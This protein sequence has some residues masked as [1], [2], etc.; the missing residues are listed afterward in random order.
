M[1]SLLSMRQPAFVAS[2]ANAFTELPF[3][4]PVLR[5]IID[6]LLISSTTP[7]SEAIARSVSPGKHISDYLPCTGKVQ[8]KLS[9]VT[10]SSNTQY[11]LENAPTARD[12]ARLR[13]TT[14]KGAGAWLPA[15]PTSEV[16]A[17]NSCE[18]RL[19]FFLRLDLPIA[20]SSWTTTCN[21]GA[22]IDDSGCHLLTCKTGGGPVW[23]HESISSVWSDCFR[24]LHTYHRREPRS[25]YTTSD[26]RPDIV[27]FNLDIGNNVDLD[28]SLAHPWSSDIFPSSAGVSG[29]AA[30]KR[31]DRKKEKYSKQQL[32]GGIIDTV[33]PLVM[34]HFG[35]WG[36]DGWK[37]LCKLS[38]K[39]SDKVGRPNAAEFIDFWSKRFSI[40]LQKCNARVISTKLSSLSEDNRCDIFA[41]QYFS[42]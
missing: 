4:F 7:I 11:L 26:N 8:Q 39:S 28:I 21:C 33:T 35:A 10:A 16:F 15:I 14:G 5:P 22:L 20:F 24:G 40:Q 37:L 2:W 6:S 25:R 17:L 29:A 19:A 3:R 12:A 42:H 18:F 23:S 41:T 34:E 31:A 32:P 1:I 9:S 30:E 13:S 38:K 36:I 27:F